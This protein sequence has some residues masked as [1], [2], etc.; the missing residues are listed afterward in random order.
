M[1]HFYVGLPEFN[2]TFNKPICHIYY[3]LLPI[4]EKGLFNSLTKYS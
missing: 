2:F 3:N 4:Q 1:I